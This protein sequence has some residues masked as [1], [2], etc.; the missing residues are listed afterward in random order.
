V[1]GGKTEVFEGDWN[2]KRIIVLQFDSIKHGKA[3]R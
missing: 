1:C 2:P 3:W